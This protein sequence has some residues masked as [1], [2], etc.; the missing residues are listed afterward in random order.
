VNFQPRIGG[1]KA[2]NLKSRTVPA[3]PRLAICWHLMPLTVMLLTLIAFAVNAVNVFYL[4]LPI[5][6]QLPIHF[7]CFTDANN[8]F[9]VVCLISWSKRFSAIPIFFLSL[10]VRFLNVACF[11]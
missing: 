9:F 4:N 1:Q 5:F 11:P 10:T 8:F 3:G 2:I 6:F 7:E